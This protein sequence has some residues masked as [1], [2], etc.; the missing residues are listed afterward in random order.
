MIGAHQTTGSSA[1]SGS[2]VGRGEEA[3]GEQQGVARQEREEHDAGFDEHNQEDETKRGGDA[4]GDPAG[5]RRARILEQ[6]NEEVDNSHEMLSVSTLH[7]NVQ[8]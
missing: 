5:D 3:G 1:N 6:I 4:H 8:N 2:A 7:L